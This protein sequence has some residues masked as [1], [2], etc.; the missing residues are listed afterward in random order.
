MLWCRPLG[1]IARCGRHRRAL[2]PLPPLECP[3]HTASAAQLSSA[4]QTEA[5]TAA[6]WCCQPSNVRRAVC[7]CVRVSAQQAG[8]FCVLA[9]PHSRAAQLLP[10]R[11]ACRLLSQHPACALPTV[12]CAVSM[13]CG[14]TP[15]ITTRAGIQW[16][17]LYCCACCALAC[18]WRAEQ[19][20]Q[21]W[22]LLCVLQHAGAA[23][24]CWQQQRACSRCVGW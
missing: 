12:S 19:Q 3:Q 7:V 20:Q 5:V 6:L 4:L 16:S 17:V 9:G 23:A 10:G 22:R 18:Q 13:C 24:C 21:C 14:G 2:R 1:C 15:A 11:D 8:C